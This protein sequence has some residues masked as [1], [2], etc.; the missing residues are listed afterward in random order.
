[1]TEAEDRVWEVVRRAYEER[2][3]APAPRRVNA[4]LAVAALVIAAGAVVAA[5][6]SPPGH[7]VFERVRKAVGVEH[8]APALFSLPGGGRLLV[9]SGDQVSIVEPDGAKRALGTYTDA[10]WSPHGLYIA[11]TKANELVALDPEG[12]VRWT[13]ARRDPSS[14]TWSGT[15]TDTRIA[16][17][18]NG[19]LRV[20]AGD[21]TGDRL[22]DRY[23]GGDPPAWD[24]ARHFTLA[25]YSGGAILLREVTG[26]I[27][28]RRAISVLPTSLAWSSDG[29]YLAVFSATRI[30]V[31]DGSGH[32]RRTISMLG[33]TL[34]TGAFAPGTHRLAVS[35][36]LHGRS[37]LHVVD[38]DR[39]GRGR[40][41][42]AGP[43]AFGDVAWSPAGTTLL[44]NWL[45]ANQWVFV[46]GTHAHAVGNIRAQFPGGTMFAGGWCCPG[47]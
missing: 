1:M 19:A 20:V 2:T 32:V 24:P 37:E 8:A 13:L 43:G 10:A 38:V 30:V 26:K 3:P 34:L 15:R 17:D 7:A 27:L 35:V 6:L 5:A 21:G 45:T 28:W 23:G 22:L 29:R 39:P 14:P 11:A 18:S 4:R 16:Y 47:S 46:T 36:R 25:Y 44:V 31:L 40:L 9:R 33:A 41:E 12:N 42:L